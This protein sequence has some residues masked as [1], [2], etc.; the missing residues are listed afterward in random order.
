PLDQ[1]FLAD[2][3][4]KL[5]FDW[6]PVNHAFEKHLGIQ[7]RSLFLNNRM[8][9]FAFDLPWNKKYDPKTR[10]GELP[11]RS[12]LNKQKGVHDINDFNKRGFSVGLE[13]LWNK[14]AREIVTKYLN[15]ESEI[16]RN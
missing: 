2:F 12:L 3:N 13:Y 16:I 9:K 7:I 11:L 1:V 4:G 8:I 14:N 6:L 5:L 10:A 15:A